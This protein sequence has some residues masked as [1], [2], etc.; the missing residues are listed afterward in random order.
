MGPITT[1]AVH[2]PAR[3]KTGQTDRMDVG[4]VI[5]AATGWEDVLKRT[6]TL[7]A[8]KVASE[9]DAATLE[10]A[11]S[12]SGRSPSWTNFS[13]RSCQRAPDQGRGSLEALTARSMGWFM[14]K[15]G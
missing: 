10:R 13:A 1:C 9:V 4:G 6:Y 12:P 2:G 7:L 15:E 5:C 14:G 3:R 8:A 11:W